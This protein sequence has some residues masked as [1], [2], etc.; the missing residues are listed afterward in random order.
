METCPQDLDIPFLPLPV[1]FNYTD[2]QQWATLAKGIENWLVANI[3]SSALSEWS[4]G[5][6][7]FW[8]AFVGAHLMFPGGSWAFWDPRIP[9]EGTFI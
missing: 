7:T 5:R 8:M 6:D 1:A 3:R 2:T 4:W 9:L